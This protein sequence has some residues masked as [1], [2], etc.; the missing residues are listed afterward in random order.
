VINFVY[1]H[2]AIWREAKDIREGVRERKIIPEKGRKPL[3][4]MPCTI[5]R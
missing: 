3:T 1:F 5:K 2:F 4:Q